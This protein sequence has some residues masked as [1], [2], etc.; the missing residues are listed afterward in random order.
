MTSVRINNACRLKLMSVTASLVVCA[1]MATPTLAAALTMIWQKSAPQDALSSLSKYDLVVVIDKSKSMS[2]ADCNINRVGG[3][4][5]IAISD[6][7]ISRWE[8]CRQQTRELS[9]ATQGVLKDGFTLVVFSGRSIAYNN[10]GPGAIETVFAENGPQGPTHATRPIND[11]FESYFARR[12]N[13]GD[14]AKPL[15][16][17]M[18]TDGCPEDPPSLCSSILNATRRMNYKDEITLTI[19]QIGHDHRATKLLDRLNDPVMAAG[20]KFNIVTTKPFSELQKTGLTGALKDA[21]AAK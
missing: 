18:I 12:T 10:V 21:I 2:I 4:D 16:I 6:G 17:L 11:Q 19:L 1:S 3:N 20:A 15:M 5:A 14:K 9:E 13:F 7:L 8:W